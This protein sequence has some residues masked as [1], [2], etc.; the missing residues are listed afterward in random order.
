MFRIRAGPFFPE[1]G[2]GSA[3]NPDRSQIHENRQKLKVQVKKFVKSYL[4]LSE[5]VF[6]IRM[7]PELC[8]DPD[9]EL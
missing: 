4:A 9:P 6:R 5:P 1:S 7:D 2:S 3:K 8:L